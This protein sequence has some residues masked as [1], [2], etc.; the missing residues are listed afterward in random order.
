MKV[1]NNLGPLNNG[2]VDPASLNSYNLSSN[3]S[4]VGFK[5]DVHERI[6]NIETCLNIK[7]DGRSNIDIYDKLK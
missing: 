2:G 7:S 4:S 5:P 3:Q 1:H 6:S